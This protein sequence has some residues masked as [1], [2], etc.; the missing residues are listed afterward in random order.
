VAEN[1]LSDD[2]LAENELSA[3]QLA[4]N[5]LP[6][7]QLAENEL[8]DDQLAEHQ[9][10]ADQL[11]ANSPVSEFDFPHDTQPYIQYTS[12][13]E[14]RPWYR[15]GCTRKNAQGQK[16]QCQ[17]ANRGD[18]HIQVL[19]QHKLH[20]CVFGPV[21][22]SL[23]PI[24]G[25]MENATPTEMWDQMIHFV[26]NSNM[27]I[28]A[29]ASPSFHSVIHIAFQSGFQRALP[30][31]KADVEVKFKDYCFRKKAHGFTKVFHSCG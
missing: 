20:N 31:P 27:S 5:E 17:Y 29:D 8:R 21:S 19:R 28:E 7:N 25:S 15:C 24:I 12:P 2:Q 3:D 18:R 9:L 30:N 16:E 26:V 1:E 22:G 13:G 14:H 23:D 11:A 10:R 6:T 4:E